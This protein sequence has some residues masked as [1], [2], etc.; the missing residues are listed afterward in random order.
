M[1]DQYRNELMMEAVSTIA[2]RQKE[3]QLS[4]SECSLKRNAYLSKQ[5]FN[6][7]NSNTRGN[8]H[9]KYV[10]AAD[11]QRSSVKPLNADTTA[12]THTASGSAHA[13]KAGRGGT[14]GM[15]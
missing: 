5:R 3:E 8:A 12:G 9:V 7:V 11:A 1:L 2:E 13:N 4:H 14:T 10:A 15:V 6:F